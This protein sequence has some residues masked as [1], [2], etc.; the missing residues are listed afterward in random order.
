MIRSSTL[1]ICY[2]VYIAESVLWL[3]QKL[4]PV[5]PLYPTAA[6]APLTLAAHPTT[7]VARETVADK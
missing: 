3:L 2:S 1:Q 6:H 7:Q 5:A 4:I